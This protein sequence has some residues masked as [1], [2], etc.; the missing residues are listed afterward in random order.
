MEIEFLSG[1]SHCRGMH[2]APGTETFRTP[3]GSP[4]VIIAPGFGGVI[5]AGLIPFGERYAAAGFHAVLFDYRHFGRSEAEPRQ[6]LSIRRQLEDWRAAVVFVRG[7]AGVDSA[8][9]VLLGTSFSGGHVLVTA[10]REPGIAA[11]V[12]Q[13]PFLDGRAGLLQI[14]RVEG[15]RFLIRV[16]VRGLQDQWRAAAGR[17]PLRVPIFGAPGSLAAMTMPGAE[18]GYRSIAP[19]GFRNEVC[20]RIGLHIAG[21]RPGRAADRVGCPLLFQLF[22]Q[23]H[24]APPAQVEQTAVRAGGPVTVKR[25]PGNHFEQVVRDQLQFL[26]EGTTIERTKETT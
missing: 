4:A 24:T 22:E 10:A 16:I 18:E 23:D 3:A 14:L 5:E 1:K 26:S 2:F 17:P 15:L 8:R 20:A 12:A 19:P 21:Y 7:Q 9:I 6:L 25:Y 13:S 11:V